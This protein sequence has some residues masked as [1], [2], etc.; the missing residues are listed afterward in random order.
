M[1]NLVARIRTVAIAI[2][3]HNTA[4]TSRRIIKRLL[5]SLLA[6]LKTARWPAKSEVVTYCVIWLMKMP[7]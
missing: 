6:K 7:F 3:L 2:V 5:Q 1:K 4:L